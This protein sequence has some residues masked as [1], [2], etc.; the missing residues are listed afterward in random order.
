MFYS[1]INLGDDMKKYVLLI[2]ILFMVTGCTDYNKKDLKDNESNSIEKQEETVPEEPVYVDENPVIVGLYQ[3]GKLVKN[4]DATIRDD[5]D[6]GSF[7]VYFTNEE[8]VG[9]TN[10]KR[11]FNKYYNNYEDAGKYKIGFYIS[12]VTTD[13]KM[14]VVIKDPSARYNLW[15]YIYNYLYDDIHQVDG[16]WYSHV[17]E[18]DVNADTIYSSIKLYGAENT[19]DIISPI[20]LTVFTYDTDDDFDDVGMYRGNSKY[21]IT[22][23]KK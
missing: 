22:I 6:I 21:T 9:S 20:T 17:E 18:K 12:F 2:T 10:T 13:R 3:N 14:E 4:I 16:G 7:D 15:P 5:L 11:N 1:I 19:K 23:N 8:N